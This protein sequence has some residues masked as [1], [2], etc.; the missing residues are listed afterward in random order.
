MTTYYYCY[1]DYKSDSEHD[2]LAAA[3]NPSPSSSKKFASEA[4][5]VGHNG[6]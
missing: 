6:P 3:S 5:Y 1:Y 2:Y 4:C